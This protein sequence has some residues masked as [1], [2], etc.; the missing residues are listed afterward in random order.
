MTVANWQ[1]LLLKFWG[2]DKQLATELAAIKEHRAALKNPS[3]ETLEV[4]LDELT[5]NLRLIFQMME[6]DPRC[7]WL[8]GIKS[9]L[10]LAQEIKNKAFDLDDIKF[11]S[12]SV[13]A[14]SYGGMG[15]FND[16]RPVIHN[17]ETGLNSPIPGTE[18]FEIVRFR[19]YQLAGYAVFSLGERG[20]VGYP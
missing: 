7:H 3:Q 6:L 20:G 4:L 10:R 2:Y 13:M 15:S 18:D 16:Y 17:P 1:D 19:L 12:G 14:L 11:L 5:L 9:D 8:T